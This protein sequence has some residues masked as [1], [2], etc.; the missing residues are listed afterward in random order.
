[1][2]YK[3]RVMSCR[4]IIGG[5]NYVFFCVLCVCDVVSG[6]WVMDPKT[7]D[8]AS[9]LLIV[10]MPY[11]QR[12]LWFSVIDVMLKHCWRCSLWC[13]MYGCSGS[14]LGNLERDFLAEFWSG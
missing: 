9:V 11:G 6:E 13:T 7:E 10:F 3:G 5:I 1:M 8:S 2:L 4:F 12:G 14:G